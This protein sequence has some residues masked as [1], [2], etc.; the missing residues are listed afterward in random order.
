MSR[1]SKNPNWSAWLAA[2]RPHVFWG[3][4]PKLR[5][6]GAY[7][8]GVKSGRYRAKVRAELKRRLGGRWRGMNPKIR[9]MLH[10]LVFIVMDELESRN[11]GQSEHPT[12]L[13]LN[14]ALNLLAD[15]LGFNDEGVMT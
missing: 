13:Q 14:I 2:G 10:D 9:E 4:H 11:G 6:V 15:D 7:L 8:Q 12:I 1:Y 5:S 3:K